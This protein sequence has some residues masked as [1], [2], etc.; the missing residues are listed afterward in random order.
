MAFHA[1]DIV[2]VLTV[3]TLAGLLCSIG[4]RLTWAEIVGSLRQNRLAWIVPLNFLFVPGIVL[5]L[6]WLFQISTDIAVA[7]LLLAAS[8]FAPVVPTFTRLALGD[9]ALAGVLTGLFPFLSAFFTPP[10]CE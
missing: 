10:V 3:I 4:L 8:P 9:L 1:D 7:M 5:A 6:I 2:R